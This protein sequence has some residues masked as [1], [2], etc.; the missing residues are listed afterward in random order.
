[1]NVDV[2]TLNQKYP[3]HIFTM[4]EDTLFC[5]DKLITKVN[6]DYDAVLKENNAKSHSI[7]NK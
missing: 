1:M 4:R 6:R 3:K 5:D 7:L 2:Q